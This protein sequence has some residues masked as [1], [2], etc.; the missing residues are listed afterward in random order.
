MSLLIQSVLLDGIKTDVYIEG[1]EIRRIG[2]ALPVDRA[3]KVIN[4]RR[5]ALIPGSY[6]CCDDAFSGLWRRHAVERMVGAENMALRSQTD[7]RR[8]V[9]GNQIGLL[10]DD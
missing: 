8:C 4:G 10:G 3:D 5:K 2:K 1:N 6:P 9:L 7:C